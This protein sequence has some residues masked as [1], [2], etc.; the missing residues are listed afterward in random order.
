MPRVVVDH[1]DARIAVGLIGM[2]LGAEAEDDRIDV[3]RVDV[4]RAVAQRG[5]DVGAA[6]GAEDQHVVERVAEHGV[7]PLVE[8]FLL[9]DRRHRLVKDVVH[10]D[11]GV[12]PCP[13]R[14]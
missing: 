13:G 9:L 5:G 14:W 10:L 7:R 1:G 2:T 3:D 12:R 11:D 8:V 4:L 6:A